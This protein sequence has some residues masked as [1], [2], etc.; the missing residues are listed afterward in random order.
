LRAIV[1]DKF[2]SPGEVLEF[3]EA[4]KPVVKDDQVLDL[5]LDHR[6][7]HRKSMTPW[8]RSTCGRA[9]EQSLSRPY[10]RLWAGLDFGI[11]K[12]GVRR[13]PQLAVFQG[14]ATTV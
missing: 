1:Q 10:C 7:K 9:I 8:H 4:H 5:D 14:K 6:L 2:G 11:W 13:R 12:R 3:K